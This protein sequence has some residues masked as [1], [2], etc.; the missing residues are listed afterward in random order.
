MERNTEALSEFGKTGHERVTRAMHALRS[1]LPVILVDDESRENEGDLI[2]AA[3]K[4]TAASMNFLI[5]NGS[6]IVCLALTPEQTDRLQLAP[7]VLEKSSRSQF[8]AAFTVSIE[9][10]KGVT[11][12]VSAADRSRTIQAAIAD[13][14]KP[15]DSAGALAPNRLRQSVLETQQTPAPLRDGSNLGPQDRV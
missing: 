4:V 3:E 1:G 14:A 15:S 13:D 10:S 9:A 2:L 12:G 6:G 11:T 8:V 7:M 5:R